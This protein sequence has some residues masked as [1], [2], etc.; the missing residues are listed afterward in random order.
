MHKKLPNVVTHLDI[1][2]TFAVIIMIIDH[3]GFY[4]FPDQEWWRAIGR[5]GMPVWFFMVGYARGRDIPN[6]LLIGAL[7][8]V[9]ADFI[10]FRSVF[11]FN[12]LITIIILRI[13][14]EYVMNFILK[15]R[16][17]FILSVFILVFAFV[18][19][20]MIVEYGSLALLYAMLGYFTRHKGQ[21]INNTFF[22]KIDY[23]GYCIYTFLIFCILQNAKF[24]FSEIQ[25]ITMSLFTMVM[26]LV[27]TNMKPMTFPEIQDLSL[28][29]FLQFCGRKTLEIYV[30]HLLLFKVLFF[31]IY[32]LK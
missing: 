28:K 7:I 15:T 17:I 21:I 25:F 22:N 31:V 5:I 16:Y 12:A 29:R 11:P 14:I 23:I 20:N 2:K 30:G 24:H 6:K 18:I 10:L 9:G 3:I 27:L 13:V 19:T 26:M 4:F 1:I 8:I 32:A